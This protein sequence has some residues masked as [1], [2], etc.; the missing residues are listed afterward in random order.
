MQGHNE[1]GH[2]KTDRNEQSRDIERL[3]RTD[4]GDQHEADPG[5][6]RTGQEGP[7]GG[8]C[9]TRRATRLWRLAEAERRNSSSRAA[10]F[11]QSTTQK[12]RNQRD[13]ARAH[14]DEDDERQP[15]HELGFGNGEHSTTLSCSPEATRPLAKKSAL[16]FG[17]RTPPRDGQPPPPG[18]STDPE[19]K[20]Q[21]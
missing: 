14:H 4:K 8:D 20:L 3:E 5:H 18:G 13:D 6:G 11:G 19:G 7:M 21:K 9:V 2:H 1:R 15:T 10:R 17:E 16:E 12:I